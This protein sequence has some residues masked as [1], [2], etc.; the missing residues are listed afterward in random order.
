V[1][2]F[3]ATGTLLIGSEQMT[4][5][6]VDRNSNTVSGLTRGSNST[7][8][9]THAADDTAELANLDYIHDEVT[10]KINQKLR[11]VVP[12]IDIAPWE[13][14]I[15][16][17]LFET[18]D[19][20]TLAAMMGAALF[21]RR[22]AGGKDDL[23]LDQARH[24]EKEAAD[25]LNSLRPRLIILP[26]TL[27]VW[28]YV[29]GAWSDYSAQASSYEGDTIPLLSGV[30]DYYYVGLQDDD[31]TSFE[32]WMSRSG[33]YTGLTWEYS[34]S[35]G[36]SALSVTDNTT[37]LTNVREMK[38]VQWSLPSGWADK[39]VSS[40]FDTMSR[41]WI[42][43]SCTACAQQGYARIFSPAVAEPY[44]NNVSMAASLVRA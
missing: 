8:A 44:Y 12:S 21:M 34:T 10:R 2:G 30:S 27:A 29:G 15:R 42:R 13:S 33:S 7:T 11:Q 9:A 5:T 28:A 26:H 35:A 25:L 31:W 6:A 16:P 19:L 38:S 14:S 39:V 32:V 3:P 37:G 41:Y 24:F 36:W 43:A 4:Y 17:K 18:T 1:D 40:G 20:R 23:M 22:Y